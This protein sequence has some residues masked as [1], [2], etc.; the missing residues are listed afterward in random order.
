MQ[1]YRFF[2]LGLWLAAASLPH[3][4]AQA[5]RSAIRKGYDISTHSLVRVFYDND[6][7]LGMNKYYTQGTRIE[8]ITPN[9]HR[10]KPMRALLS[11]NMRPKRYYGIALQHGL[12]TPKDILNPEIVYG[13][14]P[15]SGYVMGGVFLICNDAMRNMRLTTRMNAGFRGAIAGG[16][17]L[18]GNPKL[19]SGKPGPVGWKHQIGGGILADYSIVLEKLVFASKNNVEVWGRA[20]AQAGNLRTGAS[21][22]AT[23][24]A[25]LFMPY[26]H[27][28]DLSYASHI[29]DHDVVTKDWQAYAVGDIDLRYTFFDA[30]MQ[31]GLL[32][33]N[34]DYTLPAPLIKPA[35]AAFRLGVGFS[36]LNVGIESAV[37]LLSPDAKTLGGDAYGTIRLT[38]QLK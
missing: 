38:A 37:V 19:L 28:L 6:A 33:K 17:L 2:L 10:P 15:Y 25:G 7:F 32:S 27:N 9:L 16:A 13:D 4:H 14:R 24:R 5:C 21:I 34:S 11:L 22:G 29:E 35:T 23:A 1:R 8:Y 3:A 18:N 36:Y 12:F 26:F 31:G 30:S 20:A